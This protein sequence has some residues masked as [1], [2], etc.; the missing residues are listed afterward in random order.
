MKKILR[1]MISIFLM[2]TIISMVGCRQEKPNH[3]VSFI[4]NGGSAVSTIT[5]DIIECAPASIKEGYS[6][7]GWYYD[8]ELTDKVEF[9]VL[10]SIDM[11]FYAKWYKSLEQYKK[12]FSEK[13]KTELKDD[14]AE[15]RET[16]L[17][18][19]T[20]S[21]TYT[22]DYKSDDNTYI[23]HYTADVW[24]TFD[25]GNFEDASGQIIYNYVN[26]VN[27]ATTVE[28]KAFYSIL[29]LRK[30]G[31]NY[32]IRDGYFLTLSPSDMDISELLKDFNFYLNMAQSN[33]CSLAGREYKDT[34]LNY[35]RA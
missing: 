21:Y 23:T 26:K 13:L 35:D 31:E 19:I 1:V 28:K 17:N 24:L 30:T 34:I 20:I 14:D 3:T 27:G 15:L 18:K 8:E 10:I 11:K 4:T 2:F 7:D 12:E 33:V 6:L 16:L 9:P 25:Y 32:M 29:S 22:F 5:D